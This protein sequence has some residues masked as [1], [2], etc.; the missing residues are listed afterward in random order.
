MQGQMGGEMQPSENDTNG[1]VEINFEQLRPASGRVL[2]FQVFGNR[3]KSSSTDCEMFLHDPLAQLK[4]APGDLVKLNVEG[5]R[6][7][8]LA[9]DL[10]ELRERWHLTT[11][12]ANH[13]RGLNKIYLYAKLV[14]GP[15]GLHLHLYKDFERG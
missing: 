9:M 15:D 10:E 1:W 7:E 13:H 6:G 11:Y 4:S 5:F 8:D 3:F 14:V 2:P 12:V